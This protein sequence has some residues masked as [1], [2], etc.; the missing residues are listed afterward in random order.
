MLDTILQILFPLSVMLYWIAEGCT[1]GYTWANG[2]RRNN[3]KLISG[4]SNSVALMDY[5]A[6]RI[7]ENVGIWGAVVLA[8]F[9][10]TSFMKMFLLGTGG[11][12][13]G[14]CLYEMA[15]NYVASGSIY[16]KSSFKWHILGYNIP[17]VTGKGIWALFGFGLAILVIGLV[18]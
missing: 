18:I 11:W 10:E 14:T 6:W 17:W 1:E 7:F 5:H 2:E 9:L 8:F 3:N 12:F 4:S 13:M 16:K 15:L